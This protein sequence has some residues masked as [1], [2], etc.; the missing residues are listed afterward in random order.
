[1]TKKTKKIVLWVIGIWVVSALFFGGLS[2]VFEKSR[3]TQTAEQVSSVAEET[4]VINT[5]DD[6]VL[7]RSKNIYNKLMSFKDSPDFHLYGFG[8][9]SKYRGWYVAAHNFTKDDD[10]H[11]MHTYGFVSG[12]LLNLGQEY[13]KSK[14]QETEYTRS[15]REELEQIFSSETWEV[16]K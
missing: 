11:L 6:A 13:M 15:M 10:L 3:S 9:G 1:M 14:G 8:E 4:E 7:T 16:S 2:S 5:A 12:D